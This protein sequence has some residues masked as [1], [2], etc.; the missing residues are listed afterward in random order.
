MNYYRIIFRRLLI[1][2]MDISTSKTA[3]PLR[4]LYLYTSIPLYL[5]TS[6]PLYRYTSIPL[7]RYTSIPLYRYTSI[8]LYLYTSIPL[9]LYTSIPL[10]RYTSIPLYLYTAIP[11]IYRFSR[12]TLIG[13]N[14]FWRKIKNP[15]YSA[16]SS[17][18]GSRRMRKARCFSII[19]RNVPVVINRTTFHG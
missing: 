16:I 13:R 19:C 8:P 4:P 18:G 15:M 17:N 12:N 7:Y 11:P 3:I 10:Y 9:Y 1:V 2:G 5:Y 6:I 14:R